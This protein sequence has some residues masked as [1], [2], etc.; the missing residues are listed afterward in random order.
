[1]RCVRAR[2]AD[3]AGAGTAGCDWLADGGVSGGVSGGPGD[4]Q[5][6]TAAEEIG[7]GGTLTIRENDISQRDDGLWHFCCRESVAADGCSVAQNGGMY[8]AYL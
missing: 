4:L 5:Q 7:V 6:L 1:M 3:H 2:A 8:N